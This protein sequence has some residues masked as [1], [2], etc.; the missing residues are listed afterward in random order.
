[1]GRSP[2][3]GQAEP[4]ATLTADD[5][6]PLVP[7]RGTPFSQALGVFWLRMM[8]WRV[9]G[10][11]PMVPKAVFIGA[12]HTS[13]RD[14]FVA[15]ATILALRL[16]ITVMAKAELF[17]GPL[18]AF[19]RWLDVMPVYRT[20]SNRGGQIDQVV[21]RFAER[22][23][24]YM[25]IAPEGTRHAAP[26][27][28]RGFYHMAVRAGV[29]IVPFILDFGRKELRITPVFHPTGDMEADMKALI[30]RY[31]GVVPADPSRLSGPLREPGNAG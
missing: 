28:K 23:T 2:I 11:A 31:Q 14:G 21:A 16:R 4:A 25:G 1:M 8:G 10:V 6:G 30:S 29:P 9:S 5:L 17:K 15:A 20:G 3:T 18:G 27:W 12:P 26:E 13:N 22:E 24:I 19:F 7:R